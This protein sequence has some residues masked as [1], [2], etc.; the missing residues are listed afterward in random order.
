MEKRP[1]ATRP[2]WSRRSTQSFK[3]PYLVRLWS[4]PELFLFPPQPWLSPNGYHPKPPS[5]FN[6][7]FVFFFPLAPSTICLFLSPLP[8]YF[9]AFSS[10]F[11]LPL[12]SSLLFF[13]FAF[14]YFS[15]LCFFFFIRCR[16]ENGVHLN[17]LQSEKGFS[18]IE[19]YSFSDFGLEPEFQNCES[20]A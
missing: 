2:F 4:G 18:G 11:L 16:G 15:L 17:Q 19:T 13:L 8:F 9:F 14:N 20:F 7:L 10:L 6:F 12:F 3:S 1:I 5:K